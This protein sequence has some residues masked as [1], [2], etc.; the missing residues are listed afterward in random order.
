MRVSLRVTFLILILIIAMAYPGVA[1][2]PYPAAQSIKIIVPYAAG[3]TD[4]FFAQMVAKYLTKYTGQKVLVEPRPG[5]G[6]NLGSAYVAHSR[7]DGYTLLAATAGS[8]AVNPSLYK[9]MPY[10]AQEELRLVATLAIVDN[11]LVV[12]ASSPFKSVKDIIAAGKQQPGKL[13][14]ASSGVGSV[15]QLSGALLG[16]MAGIHMVHVPYQGTSPA[17]IDIIGGRV[18]FMFANAPSVVSL[19]KAGKLRALAVTGK[20]RSPALPNVPT[21]EEAGV[22]GFVLVSWY[23]IMGPYKMPPDV[24]ATLNSN[25]NRMLKEPEIKERFAEQSSTPFIMS[26]DQAEEFFL[27]ELKTWEKVVKISGARVE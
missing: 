17:L 10:N 23:G 26:S 19:V 12:G 9:D 3:G 5:A 14:Y 11:V 18:S 20:N 22:R 1:A 25:I 4:H 8:N 21:M 6:G 27:Q 2:P 16:N 7:A 24:I 13:T 15:L